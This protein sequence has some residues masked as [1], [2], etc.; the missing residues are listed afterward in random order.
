MVLISAKA[1]IV[2]EVKAE[3]KIK[4]K[5]IRLLMMLLNKS[6]LLIQLNWNR[7]IHYK[8]QMR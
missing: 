6:L 1:K 8:H 2:G 5:I 3:K 4:N 7:I